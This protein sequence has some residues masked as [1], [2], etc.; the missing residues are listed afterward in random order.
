MKIRKENERK[1]KRQNNDMK[2]LEEEIDK[3][4]QIIKMKIKRHKKEK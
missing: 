1:E 4:R 2:T 3:S